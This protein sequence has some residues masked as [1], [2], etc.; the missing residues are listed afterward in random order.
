MKK[1]LIK[2]WNYYQKEHKL[3]IMRAATVKQLKDELSNCSS[4]E[5]IELILRLSKF[6]KEN[7]ELLTYLLYEASY[8]D[9]YIASVKS[10]IE[11]QF[12]NINTSNY[13]FIKKTARKILRIT[14]TYI[15]YSK[16]KETEVELLMHFCLELK[17]VRPSLK[18]NVTL[19]NLF[20]RQVILIEKA[21]STL[22]EDLQYDYNLELEKLLK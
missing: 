10:E 22:H 14:K 9:G 4:T 17:K 21:I 12:K 8:E 7:K 16:K 18:H 3:K 19:Q 1:E 5:L 15:R 6:K 20:N 2:V 13:Y 11:E